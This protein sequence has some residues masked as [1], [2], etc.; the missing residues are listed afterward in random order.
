M[1]EVIKRRQLV[2]VHTLFHV[3]TYGQVMSLPSKIEPPRI[4]DS[5]K[6]P[7]DFQFNFAETLTS[8]A[9]LSWLLVLDWCQLLLC[10][11][12]VETWRR[13]VNLHNALQTGLAS[14]MSPTLLQQLLVLLCALNWLYSCRQSVFKKT[15]LKRG[16]CL[17]LILGPRHAA[18]PHRAVCN[19]RGLDLVLHSSCKSSATALPHNAQRGWQQM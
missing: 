15:R 5:S 11:Q 19:L 3:T 18:A 2:D 1:Q 4:L 13:S 6:F 9:R 7:L 16:V 17:S 12:E 14:E 8:S 10:D